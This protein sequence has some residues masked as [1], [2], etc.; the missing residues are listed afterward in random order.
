MLKLNQ[1][2]NKESIIAKQTKKIETPT[3]STL[4]LQWLTYVLWAAAGISAV[5]LT[6]ALAKF[7][8]MDVAPL[9]TE[10]IYISVISL[11]LLIAAT[12]LDLAYSKRETL[13]KSGASAIIMIFHTVLFVIG[14][15]ISVSTA[16][17][18]AIGLFTETGPGLSGA[19]N[20]LAISFVA[21]L[22]S[23]GLVFRT[24]SPWKP[25]LIR[26]ISRLS[27]IIVPAALIAL[28][29]FS[30]VPRALAS[31]NDLMVSNSLIIIQ[32]QISNYANEKDALPEDLS[33]L[34][35]SEEAKQATNDGLIE[36]KPNT[37]PADKDGFYYQLCGSY[38]FNQKGQY[39]PSYGQAL[40]SA[41]KRLG[42]SYSLDPGTHQAGKH[43]YKLFESKIDK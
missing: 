42:Y 26:N 4:I 17:H 8:I 28:G 21:T 13:K 18:F 9:A 6:Q 32:G 11:I 7:L 30:L 2:V 12:A 39:E 1:P 20:G 14:L 5:L 10:S 33:S 37:Q 31:K 29:F 34:E 38:K 27:L 3:P 43:C 24:I 15:I 22:I 36:Y 16:V 35:L 19:K 40:P 41:P 25:K 23:I